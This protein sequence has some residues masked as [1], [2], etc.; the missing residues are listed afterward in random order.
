MAISPRI[1]I[2]GILTECNHLGGSSIDLSIYEAGELFRDEQVLLQTTSVVAGMLGGLL[3]R[4]AEPLPLIF[5]SACPAGPMTRDCYR[6]LRGEW[7]ERLERAVPVDGVLLP[8]HGSARK[9]VGDCDW[10]TRN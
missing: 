7:F 2:G 6:Q 5:A 8:L 10:R 1:A 4:G 3:E 9:K